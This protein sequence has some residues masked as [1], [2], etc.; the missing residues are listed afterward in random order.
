M[1]KVY[2][3][4]RVSRDELRSFLDDCRELGVKGLSVLI[5]HKEEIVRYLTQG[6]GAVR[7]VGAAN[8]L[9]VEETALIGYNTDYRAFTDSLDQIF[10][11]DQAGKSLKGK[12]ALVL[13][14]GGV[15]KAIVFGLR[16]REAEVV[17]TSRTYDRS[18]HLAERF[19]G[20]PVQWYERT[21]VEAELLINATPI[22]MHPN[23]D[24][25][26]YDNSYLQRSMIV[27]DTV[28]NPEQTLLVKEARAKGCQ[29]ITGVD[30]FIRQAALQ[31]QHFTGAD[32]PEEVMRLEYKRVLGPAIW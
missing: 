12:T 5:P 14:A 11:E 17:I 29:V 28:Y 18:R 24:E 16:R 22:G 20:R 21:K 4:F 9:L 3:P 10:P 26:P 6:D 25:S 19:K 1:D 8:S 27:F 31:F 15:S 30:M 32:A 23:V 13:G 7:G 2:V